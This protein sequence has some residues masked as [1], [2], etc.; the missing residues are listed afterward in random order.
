MLRRVGLIDLGVEIRVHHL[1]RE[2]SGVLAL[3]DLLV[4]PSHRLGADEI[5]DDRAAD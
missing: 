3:D 5:L 1:G 4:E 2:V